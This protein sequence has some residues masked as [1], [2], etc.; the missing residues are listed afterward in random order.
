MLEIIK[1]TIQEY[2]G[3]RY[4]LC[5]EYFQ[6]SGE[7]LHRRIWEDHHGPVPSG[8]HVHHRDGN[9][10]NNSLDNLELLTA[11]EHMSHHHKGQQR[12]PPPAAHAAAAKWHG[13]PEGLAWHHQHY[14]NVRDR[15]HRRVQRDCDWCGTTFNG[16][17]GKASRFCCN[18]CKT[19]SRFAS[20]VDDEMR[21]C[22]TCG[23]E[24][25]VNKYRSTKTCSR[26]CA[27]AL[28]SLVRERDAGRTC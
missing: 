20:G 10:R 18:G 21:S 15:L 3:V 2:R 24:F 16:L 7:R 5:G 19:K 9:K 17:P 25:K 1:E 4:Y 11:A 22:A 27:H 12:E 14:A 6:R 23:G 8:F 26:K 13:S 28:Q